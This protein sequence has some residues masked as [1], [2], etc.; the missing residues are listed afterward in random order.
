LTVLKVAAWLLFI[1]VGLLA[2]GLVF[3]LT[4]FSFGRRPA[5]DGEPPASSPT[6][7]DR[8]EYMAIESLPFTVTGPRPDRTVRVPPPPPLAFDKTTIMTIGLRRAWDPDPVAPTMPRPPVAPPLL[9]TVSGLTAEELAPEIEVAAQAFLAWQRARQSMSLQALAAGPEPVLHRAL[10][11][12]A[13][14]NDASGVVSLET[15]L[16]ERETTAA[17]RAVIALALLHRNE[18]RTLEL[19]AELVSDQSVASQLR[20]ALLSWRGGETDWQLCQQARRARESKCFWLDLL[21]Q[22][23]IDP[24]AELLAE[25]LASNEPELLRRGVELAKYHRDPELRSK[26]AQPHLHDMRRPSLRMAAVELALFNREP[27]AWMFCRQMAN[28]PEY[29]RATELVAALGT[30]SDLDPLVRRLA[31]ADGQALWRICRS[32]RKLAAALAA[33]RL[34]DHHDDASA[35]MALRYAIGDPEGD[36]ALLDRWAALEPSLDDDSRYLH[37][38]PYGTMNGLRR[39]FLGSDE[40]HWA[41]GDELFF[42]S[43]GEIRWPRRGF[44]VD[45]LAALDALE[46]LTIDFE[47]SFGPT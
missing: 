2:T 47:Q 28:A 29:P 16:R 10:E 23:R 25:L 21:D 1:G 17:R 33:L 13:A 12:L 42:R 4:N 44:A 11:V 36:G 15:E 7:A 9:P 18:R 40:H 24:G 39:C 32:G 27:I 26:A 43:N 14:A 34:R 38:E 3:R 31:G 20:E 37:G 22:R 45:V 5:S 19:I 35:A 30:A 6:V 46:G 8:T 41:L